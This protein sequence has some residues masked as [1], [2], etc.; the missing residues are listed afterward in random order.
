M[1]D[2]VAAEVAAA[3]ALARDGWRPRAGSCS[4]VVHRRRGGGRRRSAPQWLCE[5]HPDKVRSDLVVNEGGGAAFELDGRRFYTLCVGEKGVFR[6]RP[7]RPRRRRPRLGPGLGDNALLKLAP[8][9]ER[10]REQPPLEPTPEGVAF[11]AALLGEELDGAER[12]ELE[13][14]LERLRAAA[15]AAR[16]LPRRAD[17]AG[18]AGADRGSA[19]RRRRT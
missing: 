2:Q 1:K 15:P 7:A 9:L 5:E 13:A 10:L 14:A 6:F 8:L 16:R 17:A 4:L 11:L 3:I 19:P 18:D 12:G